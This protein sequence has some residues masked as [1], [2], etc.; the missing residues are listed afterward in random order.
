M[1]IYEEENNSTT[2]IEEKNPFSDDIKLTEL[3][4][5]ESVDFDSSQSCE[6]GII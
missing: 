1:I 5:N 2:K 4:S 3:S 6:W